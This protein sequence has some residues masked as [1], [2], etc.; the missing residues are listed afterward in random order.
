MLYQ[1]Y[2]DQGLV[3]ITLLTEN[4]DEEPPDQEELKL[5]AGDFGQTFP[6]LSDSDYYI[7]SFVGEG[8]TAADF[9]LLPSF[10]LIGPGAKII[11]ANGDY[12][13]AAIEAALPHGFTGT[14]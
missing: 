9:G 6:V 1:K 5:W 3:I 10:T 8:Q 14:E 12:T 2:K 11:A 13:E 4:N 7:H